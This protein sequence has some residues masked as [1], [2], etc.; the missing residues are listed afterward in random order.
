M[1]QAARGDILCYRG[2]VALD[3]GDGMLVHATA[4][5]M[6]V[7]VE[8]REALEARIRAESGTPPDQPVLRAIRRPAP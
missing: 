7:V 1:E 2:H 3:R 8:P 6:A 5:F 4:G